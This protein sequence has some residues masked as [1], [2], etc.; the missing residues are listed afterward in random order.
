MRLKDRITHESLK[1]FSVKGYLNTSISD[2]MEAADTSK[3]GFYNHYDSKETHNHNAAH[4]RWSKFGITHILQHHKSKKRHVAYHAS[5]QLEEVVPLQLVRH[6]KAHKAKVSK[7]E[8]TAA[9]F[10]LNTNASE[11]TTHHA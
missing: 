10:Q 6:G 3:G 11:R 8:Y 9:E 2:I 4:A 7:A 1:L 5:K